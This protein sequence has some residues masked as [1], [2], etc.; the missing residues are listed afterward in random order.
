MDGRDVAVEDWVEEVVNQS[1][2]EMKGVVGPGR[3]ATP[4]PTPGRWGSVSVVSPTGRTRPTPVPVTLTRGSKRMAMG[5]S[6]PIRHYQPV[7]H[8]GS[9]AGSV[10]K[11][12]LVAVARVERKMEEK[13]RKVEEA[14]EA[15]WPGGI[16]GW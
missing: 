2:A 7:S 5:T 8:P 10:L 3:S 12:I 13:A 1:E 14:A 15:R 9:A 16:Q 6:R 4:S 11:Q